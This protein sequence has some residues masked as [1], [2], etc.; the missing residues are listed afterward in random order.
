MPIGLKVGL[1]EF[2][3]N[4]GTDDAMEE[5]HFNGSVRQSLEMMNGDL[6]R[7]TAGNGKQGFLP[8]LIHSEMPLAEK[9]EHLFL[10]SLSRKPTGREL[11]AISKIMA[12]AQDKPAAA[13][14][15]IWWALLNSNEF[16]LDH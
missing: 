4:M 7:Q 12:N 8:G 16:I 15:D 5:S 3:R 14:E 1:Q 13:L 6:I 9:V 2:N 11:S 10:A